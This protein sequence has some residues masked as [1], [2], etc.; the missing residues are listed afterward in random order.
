MSAGL[1]GTHGPGERATGQPDELAT[2]IPGGSDQPA[3]DRD[4][5]RI[6]KAQ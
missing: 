1:F 4:R 2:L 6:Q 3:T 5:H